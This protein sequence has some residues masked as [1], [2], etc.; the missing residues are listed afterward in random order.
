MSRL[1][2]YS[3]LFLFVVAALL[4]VPFSA[5]AQGG[6]GI[7]PARLD[8]FPAIIT[9]CDGDQ[10]TR[11][12]GGAVWV[13]EGKHGQAKWHYGAVADL[14][15]ERFDGRTVVIRRVDPAGTYSS[16][17]APPGQL[18]T[19]VYTGTIDGDRIDG[20]V[21]WGGTW[22]ARIPRKPCTPFAECPLDANQV[23][24]LGQNAVRA[25]QY[26]AALRCFLIAADQNNAN[27]QGISGL[28]LLK[29][30][31][32]APDYE[33][34]F[35]RLQQSAEQDDVNGELG[36]AQMYE[37]G[38]GPTKRKDPE[39]AIF[40][41]NR[42]KKRA[43]ELNAQQAQKQASQN[44]GALALGV[45][46]AVILADALDNGD[47][48]RRYRDEGQNAISDFITELAVTALKEGAKEGAKELGRGAAKA[49]VNG[50]EG[51]H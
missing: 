32:T 28:M 40:W 35:S 26:S 33:A 47:Q 51:P 8:R 10:C 2:R 25:E 44:F 48:P 50:G 12:G 42:A 22:Y 36:L 14:T 6:V 39:R 23:F 24:E 11:G 45:L 4:S 7:Q 18:F 21:S 27:A 29:G 1:D 19:A 3:F 16:R 43:T 46:G 31:G 37:L 38:L 34:A 9:E 49:V 15:I 5:T 41:N 20:T 30:V 13:F 17:F